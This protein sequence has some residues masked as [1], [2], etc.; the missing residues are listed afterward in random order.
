MTIQQK[1]DLPK[2]PIYG[3]HYYMLIYLLY[4]AQIMVPLKGL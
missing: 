2:L 3:T 1:A 4:P